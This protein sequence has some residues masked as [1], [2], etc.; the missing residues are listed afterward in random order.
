M[1]TTTLSTPRAGVRSAFGV[2]G[3]A[4]ALAAASQ[5]AIPLPGTPVPFTL[6]PLVVMLAGLWLGPAAAV[7]SMVVYIAMG[8]AGLP[9]FAPVGAPGIAR[10]FGPTGGYILA[11]PAAAWVVAMLAGDSRRY[12]RRAAAALAGMLVLYLGGFSQLVLI[13][14][15]ASSA[16][17]LGVVPFM[18]F[19]AIKALIAGAVSP[20]RGERTN[21]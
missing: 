21:A 11:Y 1:P 8:A 10:L 13:T 15:S 16:L 12:V 3:F 19:D 2:I 18:A 7:A 9:V 5:V 20:A 4:I 14:G 6:Q 17:S